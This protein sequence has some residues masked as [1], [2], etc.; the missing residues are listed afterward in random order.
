M[1][2]KTLLLSAAALAAG[3]TSTI[4]QSNVYSANVVGY[5]N[6][7]N[8]ANQYVML[9]NPLDNGTNDLTSLLASA[10]N[11]ATALVFQGGALQQSSKTKGVWSQNLIVP[12]GTGFFLKSPANG[13]NTFVGNVAGPSN[14][15]PAQ[16][17]I[18]L[19]VGS[20]IPFSGTLS[21]QGTNTMNLNV[22]PN[23]SI[24]YTL[25]NGSLQQ[26]SK[27]KGVWTQNFA[28]T[29]GEGFYLK[30]AADTNVIQTLQL[31]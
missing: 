31:Q 2:T 21:D 25:V 26:S 3:L 4:A 7:T 6:V 18:T 12:P 22:L 15:I 13:T 16:A 27:T 9:A 1:R 29:P 17:N 5:V 24:I 30:S 8:A 19:L 10:P 28:I 14:S 20:P 11:G 23:G